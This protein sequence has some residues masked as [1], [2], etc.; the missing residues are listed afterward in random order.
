M[1]CMIIRQT[2]G[3]CV[4][5]ALLLFVTITTCHQTADQST[6]LAATQCNTV[7]PTTADLVH[8]QKDIACYVTL[9]A[10]Q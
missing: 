7:Q 1:V 2:V 6:G 5:T 9:A 4:C 8:L 3:N 10:V